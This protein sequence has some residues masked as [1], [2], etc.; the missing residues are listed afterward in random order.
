MIDPKINIR[1]QTAHSPLP[2][3]LILDEAPFVDSAVQNRAYELYELRGRIDG[4]AEHDWY[5]AE[6]DLKASGKQA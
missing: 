5:Q 4:R 1:S 2:K 6:S 3:S